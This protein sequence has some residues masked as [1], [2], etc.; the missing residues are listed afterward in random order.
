MKSTIENLNLPSK[1]IGTQSEK[2]NREA[3]IQGFQ[4]EVLKSNF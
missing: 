1:K 4:S 2:Q 3:V